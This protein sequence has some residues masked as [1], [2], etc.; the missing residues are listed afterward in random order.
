MHHIPYPEPGDLIE[1]YLYETQCSITDNYN[2]LFTRLEAVI[3][4]LEELAG[5]LEK[6]PPQEE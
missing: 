1:P 3:K 2:E 6:L 4:R 5:K